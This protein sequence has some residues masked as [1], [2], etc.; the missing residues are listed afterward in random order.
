VF[1]LL[2]S[3]A[4]A[5]LPA[6]EAT[7]DEMARSF[8]QHDPTTDGALARIGRGE[9][10]KTET[11]IIAGSG[12]VVLGGRIEVLSEGLTLEAPGDRRAIDVTH[13][14]AVTAMEAFDE[15]TRNLLRGRLSPEN[16]LY[17]GAFAVFGEDL[18][19]F[20]TDAIEALVTT[21]SSDDYVLFAIAPWNG[22]DWPHECAV[23][24][25]DSPGQSLVDL[26]GATLQMLRD[27]DYETLGDESRVHPTASRRGVPRHRR[28]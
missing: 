24:A 17:R 4:D 27:S 20:A 12:P 13:P 14:E 1:D 2:F 23:H 11:R 5:D 22:V 8:M 6:Y 7:F 26:A 21:H 19:S 16:P 18:A 9:M 15:T 28:S 3:S 25:R 10:A